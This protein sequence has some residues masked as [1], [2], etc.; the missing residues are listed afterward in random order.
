MNLT[1]RLNPDRQ[2][3]RREAAL[4]AIHDRRQLPE[5]RSVPRWLEW[6]RENEKRGKSLDVRAAA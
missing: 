5:R 2:T 4:P 3:D 1:D 6:T